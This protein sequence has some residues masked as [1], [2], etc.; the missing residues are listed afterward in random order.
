MAFLHPF[1]GLRYN[2][3]IVGDLNRVVAQP[4]DKTTSSMQADYYQSSP[5]NVER[6]TLNL[7]KKQDPETSYPEAGTI[8]KQWIAEKVLVQDPLPAMYA[9]YQVYV[10]EGLTKVQRGLIALLDLAVSGA[11]IIP[12]EQTLAA[13][14]QDRLRLIRSLEGNED[15]IYM[16]YSDEK[17]EVNSVMEK[18]ISG[19]P[20]EIEVTD[21]YGTVHRIWAITDSAALHRIQRIM[22]TLAL[23]IADGH[24]RFETSVTFMKECCEK[25]WK[26]AAAESFDKRMVTCFNSADGVTILPT[27]R[28]IRDLTAFDPEAF[29]HRIADSFTVEP[30]ASPSSLWEEMRKRRDEKVFGFYPA[31]LRKFYLLC[32]K[33]GVRPGTELDVSVLHSLLLERFLEIDEAKLAAQSNIDYVRDRDE[34]IQ[35]VEDGK[36]QAAFFLNPTTAE[37]LQRVASLGQRMP[38]K[39]TDFF[40][41]LLTGLVFMKMQIEKP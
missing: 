14:K 15:L 10:I 27:H 28:L 4:Y 6:I 11:G 2:R 40:P 35:L 34:G 26:P 25:G 31:S 5:F 29:L 7:E 24:H 13:P 41:K 39:S 21:E 32:L 19:R 30:V 23:F 17:L 12:H 1:Q 9:Y 36:Y 8:F 20:P 3:K 18:D 16:L 33:K 22:S 37:Q 38:Q